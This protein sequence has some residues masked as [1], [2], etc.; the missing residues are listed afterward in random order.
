MNRNHEHEAPSCP[1]GPDDGALR[2]L[3]DGETSDDWTDVARLH[4]QECKVCSRRMDL[5]SM[6]A[7]MVGRRMQIVFHPPARPGIQ[8]VAR[9]PLRAITSTRPDGVLARIAHFSQS[10][11]V[12]TAWTAGAAAVMAVGLLIVGPAV[13]SFAEGTIQSFRVQRIQAVT[14]DAA[15]IRS[16]LER[17]GIN[18]TRLR[19]ALRYQG[20]SEP[21]ITI[22]SVADASARSGLKLRAPSSLPRE[23]ASS[24]PRAVVVMGSSV[25]V[26]VDAGKLTALA[27]DAG[28]KDGTLGVRIQEL[29]GVRFKGQSPTGAGII[30]G[31]VPL[32]TDARQA[33]QRTVA[34]EPDLGKGPILVVGQFQAPQLDV[35]AGVNVDA[36]KDAVIG[37][38]LL[39]PELVKAISGIRDWKTTLPLVAPTGRGEVIREVAVDGV[40]AIVATRA[41]SPL[42][43]VVWVRDETIHGVASNLGEAATLQVARSLVL[44][45]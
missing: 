6:N 38:G 24:P 5:I 17:L 35:P 4:I 15:V 13:G 45:K 1:L 42:V 12:R 39:P 23:L 30:W 41:G 16:Q 7:T 44:A 40:T 18:E 26:T 37:S 21:T 32:P 14:V 43:T 19:D 2:S 11:S 8:S 33:S 29:D 34:G 10:M 20:P 25:E 31:D 27:R 9:P 22:T 3:L 36:L 28:A